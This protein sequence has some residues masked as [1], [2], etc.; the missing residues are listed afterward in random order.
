MTSPSIVALTRLPSPAMNDALRPFAAHA[1]I[2]VSRVNEQHA[3][4]RAALESL[5]ARV[6]VIPADPSSPDCVFIEDTAVVL[7]EV[8]LLCSMGAASRRG[9][10]RAV[11]AEL[12]AFREVVRV[13]LPATIDGGDVAVLGRTIL[14]GAS[15]RTNAEGA[16]ALA[17][18]TRHFGY[19]VR[20]VPIRGCLHLKTACTALPDGRLLASPRY[21]DLDALSGID[22]IDVDAETANVACVG[23]GV[24]MGAAYEE[25]SLSLQ[26]EGFRVVRVDLSEL[27]KADGCATCLSLLFRA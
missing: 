7:D 20:R 23:E 11:E 15:E 1:Q 24:C 14:V 2:D 10:P 21:L 4:Y 8:A 16:R 26:R 25:T 19:E 13:E 22:R 6:H 17:D 9:E 5:G 18:A 27:A 12:R 3:A